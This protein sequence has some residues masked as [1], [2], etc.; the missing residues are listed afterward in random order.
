MKDLK[1]KD[2]Y[3]WHWKNHKK[4]TI[5]KEKMKFEKAYESFGHLSEE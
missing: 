5:K 2:E 3:H 1:R 4:R